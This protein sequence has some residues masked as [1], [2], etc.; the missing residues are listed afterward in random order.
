[1]KTF[2]IAFILLFLIINF[3]CMKE[4]LNDCFQSTGNDISITKFVNPFKKINIG[5]NFKI[6]ILQDTTKSEYVK[7]TAGKNIINQIVSNVKDGT[8]KIQNKNTCN[9]VRSYKR[10]ITIE[11]NVKTLDEIIIS[12]VSDLFSYDTLYFE[13]KYVRLKNFGLGDVN[14][15]IKCGFLD[16]Q[17]INS[18]N[19]TLE[20]FSNIMSCSIE[21][22]SSFDARKLLC[23][24]IYIDCHTPLDCFVYPKIKLYVKIFNSGNVF[25]RDEYANLKTYLVEQKGTGSLIKIQ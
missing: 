25:Y 14:L 21:E 5:E 23:D 10:K 13:N 12:S 6:I 9:F 19:I 17:S 16:V 18:G 15:K 1:M 2:K 24:D 7:I 20:G 4:Q 22:V 3:S 11:I 8:L